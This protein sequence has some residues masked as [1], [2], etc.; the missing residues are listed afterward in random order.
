MFKGPF[1]VYAGAEEVA[2]A[3]GPIASPVLLDTPYVQP[4]AVTLSVVLRDWDR[5]H[6]QNRIKIKGSDS[7]IKTP[8]NLITPI[9]LRFPVA[10]MPTGLQRPVYLFRYSGFESFATHYPGL[11]GGFA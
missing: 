2:L 8:A 6:R 5:R 9:C 3:A 7:L 4:R 1:L 11:V 10:T